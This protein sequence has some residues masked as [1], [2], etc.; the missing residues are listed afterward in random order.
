MPYSVDGMVTNHTGSMLNAHVLYAIYDEMLCRDHISSRSIKVLK[1]GFKSNMLYQMA[2]LFSYKTGQIYQTP[3]LVLTRV[4]ARKK[5]TTL[6][7]QTLD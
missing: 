5:Y 7:I 2:T 6:I 3:A 4:R 1:S